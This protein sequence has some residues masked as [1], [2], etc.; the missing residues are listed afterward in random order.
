MAH[1]DHGA[2]ELLYKRHASWMGGRLA[3]ATSSRDLA[4]EALQDSFLAAWRHASTFRHEGEVPAWL[5]GI[6]R[7]R[8]I[9][10][11]RKRRHPTVELTELEM[12]PSE[13]GALAREEAASVREAI[14][15]LP[16]DQR[17]AI[18]WVVL[19]DRP[20][21]EVAQALGVP[22]GTVKSRLHRARMRI[23]KDLQP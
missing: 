11:S 2:L 19:H 17:R 7:R 6:A 13:D 21:E 16:E 20:L 3:A 9:D 10:L 5:W 15:R 8:L 23:K 22:L 12:T 1:G 18:E 14:A 4:E